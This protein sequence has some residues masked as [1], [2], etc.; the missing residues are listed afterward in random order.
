MSGSSMRDQ[1]L[2]SEVLSRVESYTPKL[3]YFIHEVEECAVYI[4]I[5]YL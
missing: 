4:Y 2:T 3:Y 5:I 1:I